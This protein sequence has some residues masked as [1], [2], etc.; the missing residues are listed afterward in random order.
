MDAQTAADIGCLVSI[1]LF[2]LCSALLLAAQAN[3]R[4]EHEAPLEHKLF[5]INQLAAQS[6]EVRNRLEAFT[7]AADAATTLALNITDE[8]TVTPQDP[9]LAELSWQLHAFAAEMLETVTKLRVSATTMRQEVL[10]IAT[11]VEGLEQ[12]LCASCR[13]RYNSEMNKQQSVNE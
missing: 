3:Y 4:K 2:A 13:E 7:E 1:C 12:A 11:S 6:D 5:L 8:T 9:Q 10:Q